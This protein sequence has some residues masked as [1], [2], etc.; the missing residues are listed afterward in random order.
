MDDE[1]DASDTGEFLYE[2]RVVE[3]AGMRFDVWAHRCGS[4][5]TNQAALEDYGQWLAFYRT[6]WIEYVADTCPTLDVSV[7]LAATLKARART[8]QALARANLRSSQP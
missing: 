2:D 1:L 7:K 4:V 3:L 5:V 6:N 8:R